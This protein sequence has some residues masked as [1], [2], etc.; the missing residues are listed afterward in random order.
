VG[1]HQPL[2]AAFCHDYRVLARVQMPVD[3]EERGREI[4]SCILNGSLASVWPRVLA[5]YQS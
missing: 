3:N 5:L 1:F 4:A 2:A